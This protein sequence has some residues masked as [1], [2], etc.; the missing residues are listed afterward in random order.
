MNDNK[1]RP[2]KTTLNS[3]NILQIIKNNDGATL[4]EIADEVDLAKSTIHN[5]LSTLQSEQLLTKEDGEYHIGLRNTEFG[6]YA[7]NR[8]P[9]YRP[10][11]IQVYRLAEST[12]EEANF[13][14]AENGTM[15]T[16]E[17][18]MGDANPRNPE[19]GSQ[20]LKVGS[21]FH[22]HSSSSG[23]AILSEYETAEVES[24]VDK[25]GLPAITENTIT[26]KDE[27][28]EE[29]EK[30]RE[31]EYATDREELKQGYHSIAAPITTPGGS[32]LGSL[33][34]GGPAYRF[35]LSDPTINDYA[36]TLLRMVEE[37]E[38]EI[39]KVVNSDDD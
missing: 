18:V 33:S 32:I 4:T 19:A 35:E 9:L 6:E 24:I 25:H 8:K 30:V 20:F 37:V 29:L 13:A 14:V 12:N 26:D 34:I 15:Y 5:H 16:V 17:Y 11:K 10:A 22:M 23:K 38:Q 36:T 39:S 1:A 21:K 31:R 28:L 7:R 2:V 27:L 3:I